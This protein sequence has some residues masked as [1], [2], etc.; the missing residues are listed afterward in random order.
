MDSNSYS[1]YNFLI[2]S[3]CIFHAALSDQNIPP[4]MFKSDMST[5]DTAEVYRAMT[6]LP[7][8]TIHRH[9]TFRVDIEKLSII[10]STTKTEPDS[11]LTKLI[12]PKTPNITPRVEK[13]KKNEVNCHHLTSGQK[14]RYRH[15]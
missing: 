8:V 6:F 15:G 2:N 3:L 4:L 10:I 14:L 5:T 12:T 9:Q 7:S 13:L 1:Y 11:E